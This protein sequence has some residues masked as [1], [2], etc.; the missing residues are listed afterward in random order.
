MTSTRNT[1]AATVAALF[2]GGVTMNTASAAAKWSDLTAVTHG[3]G[4][5]V[6][7][8]VVG[9]DAYSR[10]DL[11]AVTHGSDTTGTKQVGRY[12]SDNY[13]PTDITTITHN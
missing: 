1:I 13:S 5:T 9:S 3:S 2:I 12:S 10:T 6:G 8:K 11:S 7:T 4:A